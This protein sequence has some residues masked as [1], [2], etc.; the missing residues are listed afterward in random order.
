MWLIF[1]SKIVCLIKTLINPTRSLIITFFSPL[2]SGAAEIDPLRP[3]LEK[4]PACGA[5]YNFIMAFYTC[6]PQIVLLFSQN[7]TLT[8]LR[9]NEV[10]VSV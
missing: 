10:E 8:E 9:E 6:V 1:I 7:L 5:Y 3:H 4:F 2:F